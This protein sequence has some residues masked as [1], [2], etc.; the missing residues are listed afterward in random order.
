VKFV[1]CKEKFSS[2]ARQFKISILPV[3]TSRRVY[4]REKARTPHAYAPACGW[5]MAGDEWQPGGLGAKPPWLFPKEEAPTYSRSSSLSCSTAFIFLNFFLFVSVCF[6]ASVQ[7]P[8]SASVEI[9]ATAHPQ[10]AAIG[11]RIRIELNITTPQGY[12]VEIPEPEHRIDDFSILEF[13]PGPD[14]AEKHKSEQSQGAN[15]APETSSQHY[16]A[17]IIA[18]I[19]KTGT[20]TFPGIP[21][22][23]TD[24]D[25]V[26]AEIQSPSV[27]IEIQSVLKENDHVLRDLKK[28]ADIPEKL[29]WLFWTLIIVAV[30]IF[31]AAIWFLR[32]KYRNRSVSTLSIPARYTLDIAESD[33]RNLVARNLPENGYTKKF[34][35]LL[36][37]IVKR[38]LETAYVIQTAEQTTIEIM[39]SLRRHSGLEPDNLSRIEPF[40]LQCDIVKFAKYIPSKTENENAVENAFRILEQARKFRDVSI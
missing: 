23:I 30:C 31:G 9:K 35:I 10:T 32:R 8:F 12:G 27:N 19:Y 37:E 6:G 7:Q 4:L 14:I 39:D 29:R 26:K 1:S 17:Q 24:N 15:E 18:A 38:I 33:L 28:Q 40:L 36:S 2:I 34:Y 25:G 3:K 20:F 16:Q 22:F 21:V 11:D 5:G 13:F